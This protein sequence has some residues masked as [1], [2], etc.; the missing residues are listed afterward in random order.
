[1]QDSEG[2]A[3]YDVFV[4]LRKQSLCVVPRRECVCVAPSLV[5]S[6]ME[7]AVLRISRPLSHTSS[8]LPDALGP[9]LM[10]KP[11][12]CHVGWLLTWQ[13]LPRCVRRHPRW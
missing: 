11:R 5:T 8:S 3:H 13:W 2:T 6:S 1:M 7:E 10:P 9:L 4:G 12:E